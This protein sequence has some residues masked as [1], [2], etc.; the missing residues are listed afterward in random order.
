MGYRSR[1]TAQQ[2]E[3][4]AIIA[5]FIALRH[6]VHYYCQ[7]LG[8]HFHWDPLNG[9]YFG[10]GEVNVY[11]HLC[12][13]EK[14]FH[15]FVDNERAIEETVTHFWEDELIAR[16]YEQSSEEYK[17]AVRENSE[18]LFSFFANNNGLPPGLRAHTYDCREQLLQDW[19]Q[20]FK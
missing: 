16:G 15:D 2:G 12:V 6:P 13:I 8:L 17:E 9:Q 4:E 3:R 7:D 10:Q 18:Y 11:A 19:L 5:V 20:K 14:S 1:L